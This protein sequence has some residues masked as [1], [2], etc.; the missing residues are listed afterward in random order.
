MQITLGQQYNV[1]KSPP[2]YC[3]FTLIAMFFNLTHLLG[4]QCCVSHINPA[5]SPIGLQGLSAMLSA[6]ALG[7]YRFFLMRKR[8]RKIV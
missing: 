1:G 3:T 4:G 2:F 6:F 5:A 8:R 7:K